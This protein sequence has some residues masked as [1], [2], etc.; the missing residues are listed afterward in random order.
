MDAGEGQVEE[1]QEDDEGGGSRGGRG[2]PMDA[3]ARKERQ[4]DRNL[5]TDTG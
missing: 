4:L 5:G 3:K 1:Q 2:R